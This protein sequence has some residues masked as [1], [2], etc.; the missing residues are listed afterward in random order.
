MS[1]GDDVG[2]DTTYVSGQYGPSSVIGFEAPW[3]EQYRRGFFDNLMNLV[4]QARPT[5]QMGVAGLDPF[6]MQAMGMAGGLGGFQ[7][8][9]QQAGDA[10]GQG[11][12]A[13]GQGIQ[14]GYY[15]AQ[16]Y[17]PAMGQSFYNPYEEDVVQRS[18]DDVYKNFATQDVA[19]RAGAV[20]QGAYGGGRGR[21]MAEERYNQLGRGMTDVA[22][23]LRHQ[24]YT[25]AQQQAQNAFADQQARMQRAG[26]MGMQG[27]QMYGNLGQGLMGLGETGQQLLRNQMATLGGLGQTARGIQDRMYQSQFD[28]SSALAKEPYERMQFLQQMMSGM[29]PQGPTTGIQTTYN[30]QPGQPDPFSII[31][32]LFGFGGATGAATGAATSG[33][34]SSGAAA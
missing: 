16:G 5:P 11:L 17:D 27:A 8:Y 33:S 1:N 25:S 19:K 2:T 24:G 30:P 29:F 23:G 13:T 31:R 9:L 7:P 28:A 21:L 20:G 22:G 32:E 34:G 14:A 12:G 18:L 26:Q 10:Y 6:E 15:G 4:Q 3:V